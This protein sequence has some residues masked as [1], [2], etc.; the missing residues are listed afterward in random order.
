MCGFT[1]YSGNDV[2]IK[3][4]MANDTYKIKHRGPDNSY[5]VDLQ[6]GWMSFHRLSIMDVSSDRKSVV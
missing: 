1:V 4:A 5:A 6:R 2:K 3:L